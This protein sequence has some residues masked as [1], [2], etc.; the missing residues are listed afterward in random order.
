MPSDPELAKNIQ[1]QFDAGK[2]LLVSVLSACGHDQ[3]MSFKEDTSA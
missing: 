2:Q 1:A 3:I